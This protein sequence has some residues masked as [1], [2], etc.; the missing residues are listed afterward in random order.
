MLQAR[1]LLVLAAGYAMVAMPAAQARQSDVDDRS[2]GAEAQTVTVCFDP[3]TIESNDRELR[4]KVAPAKKEG[5][6]VIQIRMDA[7]PKP[8][9]HLFTDC[10]SK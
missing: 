3:Q 9:N 2:A 1:K 6:E 5:A 8:T 7:I 4:K 10:S